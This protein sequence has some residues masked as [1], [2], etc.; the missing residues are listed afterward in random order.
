MPDA[1]AC[2]VGRAADVGA[3]RGPSGYSKD[4]ATAASTAANVSGAAMA[5][6][7]F[8][9]EEGWPVRIINGCGFL[10]ARAPPATV[11][12]DRCQST[13]R[14]GRGTWLASQ[15]RRPGSAYR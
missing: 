4:T 8:H 3:N 1:T 12:A 5:Q 2:L 10:R 15:T 11:Q 14:R 6:A 7:N 9:S 13:C